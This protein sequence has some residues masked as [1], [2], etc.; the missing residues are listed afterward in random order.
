MRAGRFRQP[1]KHG[2]EKS[3][4][5]GSSLQDGAPRPHPQAALIRDPL[6]SATHGTAPRRAGRIGPA[7]WIGPVGR[8]GAVK[9][10]KLCLC[11]SHESEA[12]SSRWFSSAM[13]RCHPLVVP[14][15]GRFL[16]PPGCV[17]PQSPQEGSQ[18]W[19]PVPRNS[20]RHPARLADP[21]ARGVARMPT[22]PG[23]DAAGCRASGCREKQRNKTSKAIVV[24]NDDTAASSVMKRA[25]ERLRSGP[26]KEASRC[27]YLLP[28]RRTTNV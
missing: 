9:R 27:R 4:G 17:P 14:P 7:G 12:S 16:G 8:T 20:R 18:W 19:P 11:K 26:E 10:L 2:N 25:L 23:R 15:L 21:P 5:A 3:S 24:S 22:V 6:P 13:C 1:T 28:R